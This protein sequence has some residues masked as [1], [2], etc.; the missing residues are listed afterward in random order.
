MSSDPS[1]LNAPISKLSILLPDKSRWRMYG[2]ETNELFFI[3][4]S[5]LPFS[6]IS[7]EVMGNY[8]KV[9]DKDLAG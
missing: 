4:D 9:E 6:I 2:A 1:W 3:L 7:P 8:I 5:W